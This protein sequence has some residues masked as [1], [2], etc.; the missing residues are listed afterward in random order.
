MPVRPENVSRYPSDWPEISDRIRFGRARGRCE[1]RG[2]CGRQ[3]E[4]LATDDR[5]YNRHDEP[6]Y[7]TGSLV[8]LTTAHL[9]HVP[10][11]CD[12]DNLRA[13]CQ[14][15]HLWYDQDHHAETR[16]ATARRELSEQMEALF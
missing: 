1:C 10:E 4:H 2:E 3:P 16:R 11:H 15:C 14:G 5:C 6:A 9:D 12:D 13:M 7:G 8:V